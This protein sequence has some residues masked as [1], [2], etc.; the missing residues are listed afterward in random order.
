MENVAE[1]AINNWLNVVKVIKYSE[2]VAPSKS[3]KHKSDE[4]LVNYVKDQF[5]T[6]KFHFF[7][8]IADHLQTLL[9]CF[10]TDAPMVPLMIDTLETLMR[11][12]K[13]FIK[14]TMQVADAST[15]Y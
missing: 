1:Q 5:K 6:I 4:T 2:G 3:P 12:F 10:Q 15:Q 11:R 9:K 8:D 13:M 14:I 7:K